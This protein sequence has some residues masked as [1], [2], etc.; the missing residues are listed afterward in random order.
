[1]LKLFY[2]LAVV[3]VIAAFVVVWVA[4]GASFNPDQL[5]FMDRLLTQ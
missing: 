4:S 3:I 2:L 5:P 1:M